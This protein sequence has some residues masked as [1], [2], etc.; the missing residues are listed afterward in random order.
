MSDYLVVVAATEAGYAAKRSMIHHND[1]NNPRM[2]SYD[3]LSDEEK[4]KI[5]WQ[6]SDAMSGTC[7][8]V[9]WSD[10]DRVFYLVARIVARAMGH[11]VA[12]PWN[13]EVQT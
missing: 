1:A 7:K 8:R 4:T 3:E 5:S 10:P 6:A 2:P 11:E 9:G 13:V 12:D